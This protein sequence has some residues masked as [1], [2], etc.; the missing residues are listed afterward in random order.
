[1]EHV[2]IS[3]TSNIYHFK[4]LDRILESKLIVFNTLSITIKHIILN[5][6]QC[7]LVKI[8]HVF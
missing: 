3:N 2:N 6:T 4:K 5:N 1:M 7:S 8:S